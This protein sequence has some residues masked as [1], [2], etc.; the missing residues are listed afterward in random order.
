MFALS[1]LQPDASVWV[2]VIKKAFCLTCST[3]Q[4]QADC[5]RQGKRLQTVENFFHLGDGFKVRDER[6]GHQR[7]RNL[8]GAEQSGIYH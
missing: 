8:L 6:S 7:C 1:D 2:E 3:A 5:G 4:C